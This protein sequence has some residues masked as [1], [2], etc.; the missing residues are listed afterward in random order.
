[1]LVKTLD[2][3]QSKW[4]MSTAAATKKS[5]PH[6]KVSEFLKGLFP[7]VKILEEV[8]IEVK[9]NKE[10]YLD[11]YI[12]IY[13]IAVEIDGAQHREYVPFLSGTR[14]GFVNQMSN[15]SLKTRWCEL[16]QITFIRL[17]DNEDEEKWKE[18]F[19]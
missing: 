8:Q 10:L 12:P 5:G 18:K 11:F 17:Q 2:G 14:E 3:I 19:I 15:D 13:S 9:K 6:L 4:K 16:N 7:T 1:M